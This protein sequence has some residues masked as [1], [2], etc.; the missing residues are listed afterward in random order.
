MY[1][2][3]VRGKLIVENKR[4]DIAKLITNIVVACDLSFGH[5]SKA[6]TVS[7]FP[8]KEKKKVSYLIFYIIFKNNI[9]YLIIIIR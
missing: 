1:L 4:S 9:M 5:L 8:K 7:K 2:L 3:A 6:T